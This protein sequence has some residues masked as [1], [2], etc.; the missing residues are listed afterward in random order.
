ME[1]EG[2]FILLLDVYL[3]WETHG[4]TWFLQVQVLI[5]RF[6]MVDYYQ[7][8][9]YTSPVVAVWVSVSWVLGCMGECGCVG[10]WVRGCMVLPGCGGPVKKDWEWVCEVGLGVG[11]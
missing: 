1:N 9:R 4:C 3:V 2:V 7:E 6:Y 5:R 11:L 8:F 10:V